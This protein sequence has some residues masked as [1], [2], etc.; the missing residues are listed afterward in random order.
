MYCPAWT[1][2]WESE[3]SE[4]SIGEELDAETAELKTAER[5]IAVLDTLG[6]T[7][8]PVEAESCRSASGFGPC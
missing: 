4:E 5:A 2:G 1:R 3:D 7:S 8:R 6:D